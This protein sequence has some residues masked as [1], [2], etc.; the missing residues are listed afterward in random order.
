MIMVFVRDELRPDG[1]WFPKDI[2]VFASVREAIDCDGVCDCCRWRLATEDEINYALEKGL[3][4][5]A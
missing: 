5:I 1:T 2:G 3:L 4:K